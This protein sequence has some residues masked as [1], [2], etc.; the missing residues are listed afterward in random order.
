M[1]IQIL[2]WDVTAGDL[3]DNLELFD[4]AVKRYTD[5]AKKHVDDDTKIGIVIK[6]LATGS[7]KE[8]LLLHSERCETYDQFRVEVDT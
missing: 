1:M 7:L 5:A 2:G 6:G 4:R 8:H 3:V